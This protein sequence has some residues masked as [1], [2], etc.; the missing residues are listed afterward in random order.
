MAPID[1]KRS[2][3]V[4]LVTVFCN[5]KNGVSGIQVGAPGAPD[6]KVRSETNNQP[7]ATLTLIDI[8]SHK[9]L[10]GHAEGGDSV[11]VLRRV[12]DQYGLHEIPVDGADQELRSILGADQATHCE[13]VTAILGTLP[14]KAR[15]K[16][17]KRK[18][19]Q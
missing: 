13:L 10:A 16:P 18:A 8:G 3:S 4:P 1:R 12:G 15:Q 17:R 19:K 9:I 11:F 7:T 14:S 5:S 2:P 6:T